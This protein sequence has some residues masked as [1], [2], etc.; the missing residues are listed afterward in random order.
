MEQQLT[1]SVRRG[2]PTANDCL[3]ALDHAKKKEYLDTLE[4][5]LKEHNLMCSPSQIYTTW[6]RQVFQLTTNLPISL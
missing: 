4:D 3:D 1:L 6:M 5:T 2:D